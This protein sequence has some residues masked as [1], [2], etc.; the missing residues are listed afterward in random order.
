MQDYR[1]EDS[2]TTLLEFKSGAQASVDCLYCIP[3]EASRTR[4]EVYGS[5]GSILSGKAP[6]IN[7]GRNALRII[8]LA[9]A[10]HASYRK[11]EIRRP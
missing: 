2:S 9:E 8:K 1:S 3:D 11:K 4:L 5:Q 6:K 10:A 7:S